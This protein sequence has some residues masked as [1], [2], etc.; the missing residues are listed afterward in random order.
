MPIIA[1][2]SS[3]KFEPCPA[4]VQQAVCCDV[5]D[6]GIQPT[7]WGD[8]WKVDIRW[9]TAETMADGQPYLVNK[10]YTLSLNEKA[11]L[12]HDLESWRGKAFTESE[13]MGFD[14]EKLIGVNCLLNIVHKQG[15]KGG[16]FANVNSIMPL[17]KGMKAIQVHDDYVRVCERVTTPEPDQEMAAREYEDES[18][19]PF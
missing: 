14:V 3:G 2:G 5:V 11:T 8:K 6:H 15:S 10:R 17:A 19:V 7:P 1:K 13:V 9:Q 12:R 18:G 16:T 4:G